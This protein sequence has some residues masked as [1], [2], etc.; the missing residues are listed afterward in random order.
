MK[1]FTLRLSPGDDL[2]LRLEQ[3]AS[4]QAILAGSVVTGVGA[5]T[6]ARLRMAGA[7]PDKQDVRDFPGDY[8]IV[9]LVG[10]LGAAGVHFHISLADKEGKVSGG[11]VKEG[12]IVGVTAEIT[13]VEDEAAVFARELDKATGFR[14][15]SV[16][17]R[18]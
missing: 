8:E 7:T 18:G 16:K 6:H 14:E 11:H 15:L 13:I 4:G 9:S 17:P 3:F 5:L 10:T 2:K 12:C 1:L